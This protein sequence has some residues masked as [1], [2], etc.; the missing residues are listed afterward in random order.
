MVVVCSALGVLG[1]AVTFSSGLS[2]VPGV[3][4]SG[5]GLQSSLGEDEELELDEDL[6][7]GEVLDNS[8]HG[9]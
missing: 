2:R 9:N 6:P 3:T 5:E 1:S 4:Y 7:G 8:P